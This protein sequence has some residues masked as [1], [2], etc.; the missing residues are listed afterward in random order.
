LSDTLFK[1]L[2]DAEFN[3]TDFVVQ[4]YFV[5]SVVNMAKT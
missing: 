1:A 2:N 5:K 4:T 3:I